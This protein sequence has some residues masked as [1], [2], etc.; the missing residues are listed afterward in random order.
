MIIRTPVELI[1]YK[2]KKKKMCTIS[3]SSSSNYERICD[4]L[5]PSILNI[6]FVIYVS[7]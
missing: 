7:I 4:A 2:K 1:L 3:F 6:Y 5:A